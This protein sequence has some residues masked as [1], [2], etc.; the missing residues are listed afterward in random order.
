MILN[1]NQKIP[2]KERHNSLWSRAEANKRPRYYGS[3]RCASFATLPYASF[4]DLV[5]RCEDGRWVW[6]P[7]VSACRWLHSNSGEI[8]ACRVGFVPG[9]Y[10]KQLATWGH[11]QTGNLG[12]GFN[13][14][15]LPQPSLRV[16]FQPSNM[17][18]T[19][20]WG[21][22]LLI[23][24]AGYNTVMEFDQIW[25]CCTSMSGEPL[26]PCECGYTCG[27]TKTSQSPN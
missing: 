22:G 23:Q 11:P 14:R 13:T 12:E 21:S 10:V 26:V 24:G 7:G 2:V 9:S 4:A 27:A 8:T 6:A 25:F 5:H 19:C 16:C 1:R 18:K 17:S 20:G 3:A 15:C